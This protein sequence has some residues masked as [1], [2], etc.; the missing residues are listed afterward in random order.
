MDTINWMVVVG[1]LA[2]CATR[3][4]VPY[5]LELKAH[6]DTKFDRKFLIPPAVSLVINV[7]L[8]PPILGAMGIP[9]TFLAAYIAAYGV[10]DVS[11]DTIKV[12][13]ALGVPVAGR[14]A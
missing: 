6:P 7:L 5:L 9:N 10:Q 13:G 14:L 1:L 8:L 3:T 12:L 4:L 11:R 2:G